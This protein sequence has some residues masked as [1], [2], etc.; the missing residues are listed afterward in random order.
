MALK[1]WSFCL[2]VPSTGITGLSSAYTDLGSYRDRTQD[3]IH[4]S[5]ALCQL[6]YMELH[7]TARGLGLVGTFSAHEDCTPSL[8]SGEQATK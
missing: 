7:R 3:F 8:T 4:I 2:Y 5:Q 1:L 6:S